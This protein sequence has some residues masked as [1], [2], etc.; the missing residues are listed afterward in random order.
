MASS[1]NILSKIV[2]SKVDGI[3]KGEEEDKEPPSE[4]ELKVIM[5]IIM[6]KMVA[7]LSSLVLGRRE[8]ETRH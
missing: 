4:K 5:K 1:L 2:S 7:N 3:F 6:K 8:E